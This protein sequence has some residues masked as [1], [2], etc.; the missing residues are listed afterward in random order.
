MNNK[1]INDKLSHFHTIDR[2]YLN[3]NRKG[4]NTEWKVEKSQT[5]LAYFNRKSKYLAFKRYFSRYI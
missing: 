1:N 3:N 4:K 5:N 2:F